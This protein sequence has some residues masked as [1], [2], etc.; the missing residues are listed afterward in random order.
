LSERNHTLILNQLSLRPGKVEPG[1]REKMAK[2]PPLCKDC[3]WFVD[4]H[5]TSFTVRI[6][7]ACMNRQNILSESPYAL[8]GREDLCGPSAKWFEPKQ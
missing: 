2:K 8:R 1:Q 6:Y 5:L 3:R 7:R 4:F